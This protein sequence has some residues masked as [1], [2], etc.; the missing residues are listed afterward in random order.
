MNFQRNGLTFTLDDRLQCRVQNAQIT[1]DVDLIRGQLMSWGGDD[2]AQSSVYLEMIDTS[3][4]DAIH[5]IFAPRPG[6]LFN[7]PAIYAASGSPMVFVV[8]GDAEVVHGDAEPDSK[9]QRV[10]ALVQAGGSSTDNN[11]VHEGAAGSGNPNESSC[12]ANSV[13]SVQT[14]D[15]A[16]GD[17]ATE[18][19]EM[20]ISVIQ[21][22]WSEIERLTAADCWGEEASCVLFVWRACLE[23]AHA[24]VRGVCVCSNRTTCP[25]ERSLQDTGRRP[26]HA[27]GHAA[28]PRHHKQGS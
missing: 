25:G 28:A 1:V 7:I 4:P 12:S 23:A 16:S 21:S 8:H 5:V 15:A 20:R 17:T 24:D 11:A 14:A 13:P 27:A 26:L 19:L 10:P 9:R 18:Q 3:D 22:I 6:P 2:L